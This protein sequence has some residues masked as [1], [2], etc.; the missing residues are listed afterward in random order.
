MPI[1]VINAEVTL[2]KFSGKGGWTYAPVTAP[3]SFSGSKGYFSTL[4]VSGHIDA[5]ELTDTHLMSM[6][7][8][9]L[10]LPVKAAIRK[11]LGKQAGDVVRLVLFCPDEE[12][13]LTV[14]ADDFREC[15]AEVPGALEA[16]E[17][18]TAAHQQAWVAWVAAAS[19][20]E[21]KVVRAEAA[22]TR[23]AHLPP[24]AK[25]CLPPT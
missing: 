4:P 22:C 15:L 18:L 8:G 25:S 23:L 19:T 24:N 1:E 16:Y 21:Q 2:E 5:F 9:R 17:R 14:S 11:E 7:Q 6:G 10:F 12:A 13:P 20:D 3:E